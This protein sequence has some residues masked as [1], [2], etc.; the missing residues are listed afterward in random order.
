MKEDKN[1]FENLDKK[2]L[3]YSI[4]A[5]AFI[6]GGAGAQAGVVYANPVDVTLNS[7]GTFDIQFSGTKFTIKFQKYTRKVTSTT[8]VRNPH[9]KTYTS[10]YSY[11]IS[12]STYTKTKHT[13]TRTYTYSTK[14]NTLSTLSSLKIGIDDKTSNAKLLTSYSSSLGA[15]M[16]KP[17]SANYIISDK[18]RTTSN[19]DFRPGHSYNIVSKSSYGSAFGPFANKGDKY[20][21]LKFK[22]DSNTHYGWVRVNVNKY[23]TAITIKDYAYED[24]PDL[25]I[26][27][28]EQDVSLPVE[29]SSFSAKLNNGGALLTWQTESELENLGFILERRTIGESE[30]DWLEIASYQT[31]PA[32]QGHGSSSSA[33]SYSFKDESIEP[34]VTYEYRLADVSFNGAVKYHETVV[35]QAQE[36]ETI[37]GLQAAYPNPFNSATTLAYTLAE[38]APVSLQIVDLMGRTVRVFSKNQPQ[39]A[40]CYTLHWN[41]KNNNGGEMSSGVYFVILQ[42]KDKVSTQKIILAR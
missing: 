9:T 42:V 7:N 6:L 28:G 22:I 32:L 3:T 11:T 10:T 36:A 37:S 34:G 17:L 21:G 1:H 12:G 29:L 13:T 38:E 41:G 35:I 18:S 4:A 26:K 15:G 27:A 30:S 33:N 25:G 23:S 40:G 14:T 31:N 19:V 5:G 39:A 16:A 2:L 8:E 24:I 20:I